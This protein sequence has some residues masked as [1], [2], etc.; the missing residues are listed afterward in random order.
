MMSVMAAIINEATNINVML[1][2]S[3][4]IKI[5]EATPQKYARTTTSIMSEWPLRKHPIGFCNESLL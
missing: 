2:S 3:L 5:G 4:L 1:A